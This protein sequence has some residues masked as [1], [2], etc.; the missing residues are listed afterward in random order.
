[1]NR[2]FVQ[3]WRD[4]TESPMWYA[5]RRGAES[6]AT[7]CEAFLD[8][9]L[10]ANYTDGQLTVLGHTITLARGQLVASQR[11]LARRWDWSPGKVGRFLVQL[12]KL[13]EIGMETVYGQTRITLR[14]Y[15]RTPAR[16]SEPTQE[17]SGNE[18][19]MNRRQT[20]NR[21]R[22]ER[23]NTSASAVRKNRRK[24]DDDYDQRVSEVF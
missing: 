10:R 23:K 18:T 2:G 17:W 24:G 9:L 13:D 4:I 3:V 5:N 20:Q 14:G 7:R 16:P 21:I 19:G 6:K 22:E 8:L 12:R 1:M 11:F 15:D